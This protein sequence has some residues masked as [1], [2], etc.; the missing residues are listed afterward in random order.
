MFQIIPKLIYLT[1][2]R[3][4]VMVQGSWVRGEVR[5]E[6]R[7]REKRAGER[8]GEERSNILNQAREVGN[9]SL[10]LNSVRQSHDLHTVYAVCHILCALCL[11]F[12]DNT[13][14]LNLEYMLCI[15]I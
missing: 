9:R 8:G 2:V 3:V 11:P 7:T 4:Y 5:T 15:L 14:L 10:H 12:C 6:N 13:N 1:R